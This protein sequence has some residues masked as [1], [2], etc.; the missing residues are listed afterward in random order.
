MTRDELIA[1][2]QAELAAG[3][4]ILLLGPRGMGKSWILGRIAQAH[5]ACF[6]IPH[7]GSK[8]AVLLGIIERLFR[9]GRLEEFAYFADW[10][11]VEK[12]IRYRTIEDLR[13]IVE[14]HLG[15]Y[16]IVIDNLELATEKAM[17]EIV[18]PL[19]RGTVLAAADI[20]QKSKERRVRLVADRFRQIEV[21]PMTHDEIR[22]MLWELLDRDEY[23]HW[24]AIETKVLQLAQGRPGVVADLA[25]Q[26][27]GST[28]SLAEVRELSHSATEEVRVNLLFPT[29]LALMALLFA[30]R[31]LARGFDDPTMYILAGLAYALGIGLRPV[32]YRLAK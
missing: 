24:Q 5:P 12:R 11:D 2:I 10:R 32:M 20:S 31:Y 6:F 21:P 28:G 7:I 19:L 9:D 15:D 29:T 1:E 4:H 3:R 8:K 25:E 27:R 14:P 30:S 18:E 26:L 13:A 16:L 23:P 22:A 17:I